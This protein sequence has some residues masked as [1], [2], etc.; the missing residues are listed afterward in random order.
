MTMTDD[1]VE[2]LRDI[3][4]PDTHAAADRIEAL[5]AE[6]DEALNQLDSSRYSVE[7]L[8]KRVAN[9]MADNARLKSVVARFGLMFAG[10]VSV[11]QEDGRIVA[12]IVPPKGAVSLAALNPGKEPIHE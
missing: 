10:S 12:V 7:V 3:P 11:T 2:R 6:R 4:D 1:L 9:F 5:T 8:E